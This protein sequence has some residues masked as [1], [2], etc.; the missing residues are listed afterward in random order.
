MKH[1]FKL[2]L[3]YAVFIVPIHFMDIE[4]KFILQI[5][6]MLGVTVAYVIAV[7]IINRKNKKN[8]EKAEAKED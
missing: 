3:L 8:N 1:F 4:D 7:L 2:V 5:S 6:C